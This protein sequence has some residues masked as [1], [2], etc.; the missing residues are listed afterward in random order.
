[1]GESGSLVI[2]TS[3]SCPSDPFAAASASE[4]LVFC[5]S[6]LLT[7]TVTF[8]CVYAALVCVDRYIELPAAMA[9][10][11]RIQG[12]VVGSLLLSTK[13]AGDSTGVSTIPETTP[14]NAIDTSATCRGFSPPATVGTI[15]S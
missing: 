10:A 2:S 6:T 9:R 4:N 3:A 1:M 14:A 12:A 11:A 15:S 8:S 13:S 5:A 7:D